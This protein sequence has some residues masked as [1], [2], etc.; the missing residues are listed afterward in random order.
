[1]MVMDARIEEYVM[2]FA[3][4]TGHDVAG[5]RERMAE[6][7]GDSD[8]LALDWFGIPPTAVRARAQ[9][10]PFETAIADVLEMTDKIRL[11]RT[12]TASTGLA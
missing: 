3:Q 11:Y 10:A 7:I 1:M 5:V 12:V 6:V 4:V 2:L 8:Y 9:F